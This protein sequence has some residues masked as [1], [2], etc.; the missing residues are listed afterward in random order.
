[1]HAVPPAHPFQVG[2]TTSTLLFFVQLCSGPP[3][4]HHPRCGPFTP[5]LVDPSFVFLVL[6]ALVLILS[7]WSQLPYQ[8]TFPYL[9][10]FNSTAFKSFLCIFFSRSLLYYLSVHVSPC[11]KSISCSLEN[12]N[13]PYREKKLKKL[14][15][16]GIVG[17]IW[18]T[19]LIRWIFKLHIVI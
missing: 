1:M 13:C 7:T 19:L 10:S 17:G 5:F 18:W 2:S 15:T 3:L 12:M 9:F 4:F 8:L 11:I 6:D 16:L 14:T